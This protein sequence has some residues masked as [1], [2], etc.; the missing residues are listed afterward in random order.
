M[1]G[2][3]D[4]G[5]EPSP[6]ISAALIRNV[7]GAAAAS[8]IAS[9]DGVTVG[10]LYQGELADSSQIFIVR[11]ADERPLGI[12]QLS[13]EAAPGMVAR[14]M[15]RAAAAAAMLGTASGRA[16]LLPL[17][18]GRIDGRS[19][20]V[21]PYCLPFASERWRWA[22]QRLR[23]GPVVL[24]WLHGVAART[25]A[26]VADRDIDV[27]FVQPVM[28]LRGLEGASARL[29]VACD[30]ALARLTSG[31]WVPRHV[32]MHGDL[33]RG[34]LLLR[35]AVGG[36]WPP[37]RA[38]WAQRLAVIDWAGAQLQGHPFFDLV[39]VAQSLGL[40]P[41]RLRAEIDRHC[42]LLACARIDAA[43]CVLAA[44]GDILGELEQFPVHRLLGM[45]ESTL[46]CVDAAIASASGPPR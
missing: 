26:T 13:A 45:A 25:A 20:A 38:P 23:L 28:R 22:A 5:P 11:D 35:P 8:L 12:V 29:V 37:R 31:A 1:I 39:R 18:Q 2:D 36:A 40:A 4:A 17:A 6:R 41:R 9:P 7:F 43:S 33:W 27:D 10:L 19:Y 24:D 16:V 44:A 30:E 14:G 42:A 15:A 21:M 34:N 32:L 3:A 46:R